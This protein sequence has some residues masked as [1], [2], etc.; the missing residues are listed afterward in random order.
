M[1]GQKKKKNFFILFRVIQVIMVNDVK[2]KNFL[3]ITYFVCMTYRLRSRRVLFEE[4]AL[5]TVPCSSGPASA[6]AEQW[7]LS[8]G[9]Q[10]DLAE[11]METGMSLSS[12]SPARSSAFSQGMEARSEP[13]SSPPGEGSA[14]R[15]SS[16]SREDE[17][18][19]LESD[20]ND[21][22]LWTCQHSPSTQAVVK[23]NLYCQQKSRK[24]VLK[25][26]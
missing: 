21:M 8:W 13:V 18:G 7:L 17:E 14:L 11:G 25:A 2:N 24:S 5:P 23:L 12:S 10:V 6:K 4:G 16:S 1:F 15:L 26:S 19:A 22:S 3:C 9:L 20:D